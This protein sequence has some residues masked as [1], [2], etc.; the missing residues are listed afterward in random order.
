[1]SD[2]PTLEVLR[3]GINDFSVFKGVV[4]PQYQRAAHLDIL[5]AALMEVVRYLETGD[6]IQRLIVEMPPRHGK[7]LSV[8]QL[9]PAWVLGRDP[10]TRVILASY[11]STLAEFNSR[12]VRSY[13]SS[14]YYQTM[15]PDISLTEDNQQVD[16]WGVDGPNGIKGGVVAVGLNGSVTGMGAHLLII[17]DP[18]KSRE[19]VESAVVREKV[20]TVYENDLLSRFNDQNRKAQI[21]MATRWHTDDLTGKII[22][23]QGDKWLR[24][25]LP[26]LAEE[27]DVLGR[28]E[29]DALWPERWNEE[30]LEEKRSEIGSYAFASLYQQRPIPKGET[31]VPVDRIEIIDELPKLISRVRYY[32]LAITVKKKSDYTVG[33]LAG[34]TEDNDFVICDVY[35]DKVKAPNMLKTIKRLAST[36]GTRTDICLEAEKA[37]IIQ[38]DYLVNDSDLNEH[39]IRTETVPGDKLTRGQAVIAR[40]EAGKVKMKRGRWNGAFL[41]ELSIFPSGSHD[42][43][44][45]AFA[46][47][48][49]YLA[50]RKK[51]KVRV[52]SLGVE[53][54]GP[55][56]RTWG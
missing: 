22:A 2:T 39:T 3:T 12:A 48:Y 29:G 52:K 28:E 40:V 14:P 19:E 11:S 43:Q 32:D 56:D 54:F 30:S 10:S 6:G 27:N 37:G 7:S 5:D 49:N 46:G 31:V 42:D 38:L 15:F 47:A 51:R 23:E 4:N 45:D 26:A 35:R 20:W 13:L 18:H 34:F 1:M 36:D 33:V 55:V 41:D 25:R 53:Q 17:D 21:L 24:L 8:S 44:F 9:F 16:N 50:K